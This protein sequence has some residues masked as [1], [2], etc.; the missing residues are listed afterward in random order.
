MVLRYEAL[1]VVVLREETAPEAVLRE[2]VLR[3]ESALAVDLDD[4]A[5][6]LVEANADPPL[7]RVTGP[8][9]LVRYDG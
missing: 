1:E 5:L 9:T 2:A 4:G 3:E 7:R 8:L 6:Y